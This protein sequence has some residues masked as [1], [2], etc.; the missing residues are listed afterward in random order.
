[1]KE[2]RTWRDTSVAAECFHY[3]QLKLLTDHRRPHFYVTILLFFLNS[4]LQ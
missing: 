4:T 2:A 3:D 1:M